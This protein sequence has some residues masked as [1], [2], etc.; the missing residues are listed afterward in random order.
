[1]VGVNSGEGSAGIGLQFEFEFCAQLKAPVTVGQGPRGT[2][3]FFET[4][5]G[6]VVGDRI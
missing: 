4:A 6:D 5:G 2:R 1:M 3:M